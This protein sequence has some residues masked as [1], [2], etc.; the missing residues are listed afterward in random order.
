MH[1]KDKRTARE[2]KLIVLQDLYR[3]RGYPQ[4]HFDLVMDIGANIGIFSVYAK[5]LFP[6]ARI[7]AVEPSREA[8][9]MLYKNTEL[10]DI[11]IDPRALGDGS[12]LYQSDVSM[13]FNT[14]FVPDKGKYSVE[15]ATLGQLF[16]FNDCSNAE[17]YLVKL[18]VEGGERYLIDESTS[19][20]VLRYATQISME[21]HFRC[22]KYQ[23]DHWLEFPVYNEWIHDLL[24]AT[25]NIQY[26]CSSKHEGYGH[27]CMRMKNAQ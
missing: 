24:D 8:L 25:H 2:F 26:Y 1:Y 22:P 7:L 12:P 23:Y 17:S 10:F 15:T 5:T 18:D 9:T 19:E 6:A 21:L 27:Y 11:E 16:H 14:Q 4:D 13:L 20:G 3:I